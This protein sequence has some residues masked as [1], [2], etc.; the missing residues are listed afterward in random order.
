MPKIPP[1]YITKSHMFRAMKLLKPETTKAQFEKFWAKFV[2]DRAKHYK[3]KNSL[4]IIQ[5]G[6]CD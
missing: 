3:L 1:R 4:K 2:V 6:K 5:G